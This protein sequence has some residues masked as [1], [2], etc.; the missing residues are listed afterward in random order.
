MNFYFFLFWKKMIVKIEPSEITPFFYNTFFG[1]GRIPPPS[2]WL[3]P[4]DYG[5]SMKI[6]WNGYNWV[7]DG[8]TNVINA[9]RHLSKLPTSTSKDYITLQKLWILCANFKKNIIMIENPLRPWGS[10]GRAHKTSE[11]LGFFLTFSCCHFNFFI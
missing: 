10:G 9:W 2:P 11:S 6:M 3:L 4:W 5:P 7:S 1:F 8:P